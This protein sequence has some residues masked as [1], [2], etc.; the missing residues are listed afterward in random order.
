MRFEWVPFKEYDDGSVSDSCD[1]T[2]YRDNGRP[3]GS[4]WISDHTRSSAKKADVEACREVPYAYDVHG[5]RNIPLDI[6]RKVCQNHGVDADDCGSSGYMGLGLCRNESYRSSRFPYVGT[7]KV[8]IE[9]AM[10]IVEEAFAESLMFDYSE[11][12]R[13]ALEEINVR[14][15][16]MDEGVEFLRSRYKE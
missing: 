15:G 10:Q 2:I 6:W 5:L 3:F 8:S 16:M 12:V 4:G 9:E 13:E 14:K 11:A 7:P 1:V